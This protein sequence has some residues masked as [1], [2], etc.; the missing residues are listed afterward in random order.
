MTDDILQS[1]LSYVHVLGGENFG[2]RFSTVS[3]SR[4]VAFKKEII[5]YFINH[6]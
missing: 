5:S 1:Y 4:S 3:F 2:K 6:Y